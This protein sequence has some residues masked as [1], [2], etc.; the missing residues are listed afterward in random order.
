MEKKRIRRLLLCP[1]AAALLACVV[2]AAHPERL[3]PVGRTVGIRLESDGLIVVGFDENESAARDAGLKMGDTIKRVNGQDVD[4][5]DRFKTIVSEAG[6]EPLAMEVQREGRTMEI[7]VQ[8]EQDGETYR[9]GLL[10]RDGM[11]GI[12]T[13]TFYDPDTGLYGAL[14]HGVNELQSM[15]L[16]PL[17]QGE[18][19]PSRVVEV[20]KGEGGS[21]GILKG[22]FDME[23]RLGEVE[24]NTAHGIF[25]EAEEPLSAADAIPVAAPGDARTGKASILSNVEG[26]QVEEFAVEI[27]R[28]FPTGQ[29]TGRNLLLTIT[30]PRLLQATGGIVQG[31]SGS[32]IIQDGKLIGA[33]THVLVDNPTQGYGIFIENMLESC[34]QYQDAA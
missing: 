13:V 19:L 24:A 29:D 7:D 25:G 6:G 8:P 12:G 11:A 23:D 1:F 9:L 27:N 21:P 30:D 17:A 28:L 32:P 10:L 16:L 20:Q 26:D 18:I 22:A 3:T 31:M 33:V 34:P 2:T 5:C 15:V 14:G 4:S